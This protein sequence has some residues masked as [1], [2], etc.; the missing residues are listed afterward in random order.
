MKT[1]LKSILSLLRYPNVD[2]PLNI[3]AANIYKKNKEEFKKIIK[4]NS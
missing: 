4:N 1:I 2:D 3:D